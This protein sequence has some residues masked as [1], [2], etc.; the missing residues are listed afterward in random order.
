ML[1]FPRNKLISWWVTRRQ[2]FPSQK[3]QGLSAVTD[4]DWIKLLDGGFSS[5][6]AVVTGPA[7]LFYETAL[8]MYLRKS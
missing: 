6:A 7:I 2:P 1:D 8:F 5:E 4:G 3:R